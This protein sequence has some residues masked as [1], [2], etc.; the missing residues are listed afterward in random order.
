MGP[1]LCKLYAVSRS[2]FLRVIKLPEVS[3][4]IRLQDV[5]AVASLHEVRYLSTGRVQ[6]VS[7]YTMGLK[8]IVVVAWG[9]SM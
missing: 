7:G 4:V 9:P 1:K 2:A 6:T 5:V 8:L 3:T